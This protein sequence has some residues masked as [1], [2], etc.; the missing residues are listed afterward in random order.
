MNSMLAAIVSSLGNVECNEISALKPEFGKVLVKTELASICGSDLHIA[1]KGWNATTFPLDAGHPGH[2][3]IG[4]VVDGGGTNFTAEDVVLTLPNVFTSRG[5]AGYQLLSPQHVLKVNEDLPMEHLMM[6][7]QLGTVIYGSKRLPPLCG[8]NVVILGQ[9]SAGLFHDFV[10]R[11]QG[12]EKII[13]VDPISKRLEI[14]QSLG[15]D[16]G[17]D[18][19][20]KLAYE[21]IMDITDGLGVDVVVDAVGSVDTLNQAITIARDQGVVVGFGL[22]ETSDRIPFNWDTFFR[23]RLTMYAI[24]GSQNEVGL[25]DFKQALDYIINGNINVEPF[26]THRFPVDNVQ[27]AFDLADSREEGVIKIS[28]TFW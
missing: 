19:V 16:F 7:Q 17:I 9:G 18:V 13:A 28:L 20:G 12:A 25:P 2:E 3:G 23:K 22:P 14:G 21:L 4:R 1:Y 26:L 6:A 10:L 5:F 8:K 11:N 24:H 27:K 15:V